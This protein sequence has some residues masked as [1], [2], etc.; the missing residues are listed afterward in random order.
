[1]LSAVASAV[2]Y[3]LMFWNQVDDRVKQRRRRSLVV[4][5]EKKPENVP[6]H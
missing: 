5:E 2:H 6:T 1:V 3:F 4:E